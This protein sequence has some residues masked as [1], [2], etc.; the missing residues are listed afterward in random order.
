MVFTHTYAH[1][2]HIF[3]SY[4]AVHR[5]PM[6]NVPA[7]LVKETHVFNCAYCGAS[8]SAAGSSP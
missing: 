5:T 1:T 6:I 7:N 4:F 2:T 8:E 3:P